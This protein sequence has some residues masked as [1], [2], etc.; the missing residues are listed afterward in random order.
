MVGEGF[1]LS[2]YSGVRL[3]VFCGKGVLRWLWN[4]TS[5]MVRE[6]IVEWAFA[7]RGNNF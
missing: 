2:N 4:L 7:L 5:G 6:S 3:N 1:V